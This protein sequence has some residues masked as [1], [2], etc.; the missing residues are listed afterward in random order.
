MHEMYEIPIFGRILE[1]NKPL[2]FKLNIGQTDNM[3]KHKENNIYAVYETGKNNFRI[4]AE[5]HKLN[6]L[7]SGMYDIKH[8]QTGLTI[9]KKDNPFEDNKYFPLHK[10]HKNLIEVY[11]D[12]NIFIKNEDYYNK[13]NIN[14]KRSY[15][16]FSDA[17]M[18]K[19]QFIS[20]LSDQI[21]QQ[22]GIVFDDVKI[23]FIDELCPKIEQTHKDVWKLVVI[24]EMYNVID[25]GGTKDLLKFLDN[26]NMKNKWL[27]ILTTNY[28]NRIPNNL[29]DRPTRMDHLCHVSVDGY[30]DNFYEDF[31]EFIT[32]KEFSYDLISESNLNKIKETLSIDYYKEL[33]LFS[34]LHNLTMDQAWY[35]I[36][37]RRKLIKNSFNESVK[38]LGFGNSEE[39]PDLPNKLDKSVIDFDEDELQ[40]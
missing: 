30:T 8:T 1:Y 13:R 26:V 27:I 2:S 12:L 4:I 25:S 39:F 29:I 9:N 3:S 34:E 7:P 20:Y 10:Y 19:S 11:K 31:Y 5:N 21:I 18:G 33:I 23:S 36:H 37:K 38:P 40:F 17:G 24:E 15:L 14:F 32:G 22:G 6:R 28:P 35:K 16:M